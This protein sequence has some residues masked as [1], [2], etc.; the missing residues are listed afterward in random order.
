MKDHNKDAF[1]Q[2]RVSPHEKAMI[3]RSAKQANMSMSAW[4]LSKVLPS[5]EIKFHQLIEGLCSDEHNPYIYAELN[6]LLLDLSPDMFS[7]I[8]KEQSM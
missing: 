7:R 1:L 6:D 4:L 2:I 8:V 5:Q 3:A